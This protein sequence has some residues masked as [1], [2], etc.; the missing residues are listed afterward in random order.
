MRVL[1]STTANDGHFGPIVPFARAC[2]TAGH[3]VRVAAPASYGPAVERAGF[4]HEPFADVPPEDLG[5]VMA[6]LPNLA[7]EE[8]ND[9]V[10]RDVFARLD[11][12]AA[13]P[14]LIETVER[15][16]P[17]VVLRESAELASVAAAER[18]GVPH[19][20]VSIGMHEIVSRFAE[21]TRDQL[22]ELGVLAGLDEGRMGASLSEEPVLS[23]VPEVLDHPSGEVP[24]GGP[25]FARFHEPATTLAGPGAGDWGDQAL[26]LVY[27]T[28]GTV[29]GSLPP[30]AGV[31]R[32]ALDAL[33]DL[34]VRVLM[35]VG[36]KI[37]P[38]SLGPV[39]ANAR[40]E[41]WVPQQAVLAEAS[42]MV[43]HGGFGTTMGALAAG[44]PQVVV[45]LFAFD[46][47]VNGDHVAAVGAGLTTGAEPGGVERAAAVIPRLLGE[48]GFAESARRVSAAMR[49]LPLPVEA[50]P[51]LAALALR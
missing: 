47:V 46:Q 20:H 25:A 21:T 12:Q 10:L 33:A 17:D 39:P 5:P 29:A 40:V 6:R 43:G 49:A 38:Q 31:F 51:V 34:D 41:Q 24:R 3:E 22:V 28:F 2:L 32:D 36:R 4:H 48:P 23:L 8:A 35:T 50:V 9:V 19:V 18:A 45:P 15:W 1:C 42:A 13:L 37:D 14:S 11:A 7:I 30:F 26:P 16:A 27:V 44:V